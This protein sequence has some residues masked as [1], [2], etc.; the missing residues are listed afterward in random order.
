MEGAEEGG[1]FLLSSGP[2]AAVAGPCPGWSK[3][4][5]PSLPAPL[6]EKHPEP[7]VSQLKNSSTMGSH[8]LSKRNNT[9]ILYFIGPFPF[10][11]KKSTVLKATAAS[12]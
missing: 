1:L 8:L 9:R 4:L 7:G 10:P 3:P 12:S 6:Q 5:L 2:H 11:G